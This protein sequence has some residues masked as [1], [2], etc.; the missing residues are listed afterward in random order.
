M[1]PQLRR[2]VRA[3]T[4]RSR[5]FRE[6]QADRERALEAGTRAKLARRWLLP[7]GV[8]LT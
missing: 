1:A 3:R 2:Y 6:Q 5:T 4:Q 7:R 8:A